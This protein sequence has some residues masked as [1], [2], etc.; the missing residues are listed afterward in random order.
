M[1]VR[2]SKIC[3]IIII[4]IIDNIIMY[5]RFNKIHNFLWFFFLPDLCTTNSTYSLAKILR[6]VISLYHLFTTTS[7]FTPLSECTV[8]TRHR[9]QE[10][11]IQPKKALKFKTFHYYHH[12]PINMAETPTNNQYNIILWWY[13]HFTWTAQKS[14][15]YS[16]IHCD[17]AC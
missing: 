12:R 2:S 15:R 5:T 13:L 6:G 17:L 8:C 14:R 7:S 1:R 16:F 4:I 10:H 9:R 3:L 11:A